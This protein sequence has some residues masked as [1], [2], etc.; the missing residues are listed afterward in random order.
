MLQ[1]E[2]LPEYLRLFHVEDAVP[3]CSVEARSVQEV[4]QAAAQGYDRDS[5]YYTIHRDEPVEQIL[6]KCRMLAQCMEDLVYVNELAA[7][8]SELSGPEKVGL[9]MVP[10]GFDD[11]IRPGVRMDDLPDYARMVKKLEHLTVRGCFVN[12]CTDG[13]FG[14]AL[15][16]Y[17]RACYVA[18]KQMTVVFPCAMP[19]L[20]AENAL[21]AVV[22][23]QKEQPETLQDCLTEASIV[24]M[25]N[26]TAFYAKLFIK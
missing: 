20:C 15:G 22:R 1:N 7:A 24:A 3:S 26:E 14:K 5:I 21:A 19:Y 17:F 8:H 9:R 25:Q 12:G 13:I 4:L 18:A 16:K 23:N 11:E 10:D 6:G 2:L